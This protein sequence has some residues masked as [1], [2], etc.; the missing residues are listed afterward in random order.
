MLILPFSEVPFSDMPF[1]D[2]SIGDSRIDLLSM[3]TGGLA[4]C[5]ADIGLVS[6]LGV[7]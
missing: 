2:E 7:T 5:L 1:S 3:L 6:R 4:G